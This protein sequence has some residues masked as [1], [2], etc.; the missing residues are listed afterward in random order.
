MEIEISK[1][2]GVSDAT[3]KEDKMMDIEKSKG[4]ES[5]I[6]DMKKDSDLGK[7]DLEKP[8]VPEDYQLEG[9]CLLTHKLY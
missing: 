1:E 9:N 6:E 2:P 4:Y 5:D 8:S 3:S 7:S